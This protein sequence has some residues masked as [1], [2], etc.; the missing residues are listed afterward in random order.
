VW[1]GHVTR[2]GE[3]RNCRAET[4]WK[5]KEAGI[6][7]IRNVVCEDMN[8]IDLYQD[9]MQHVVDPRGLLLRN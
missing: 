5:K 9:R 8:W 2:I 3:T 1:V 6:L 7:D 4:T